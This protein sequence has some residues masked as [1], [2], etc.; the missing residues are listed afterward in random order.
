M[1]VLAAQTPRKAQ[2]LHKLKTAEH[3]ASKL[4]TLWGIV[5][6]NLDHE[7][8]GYMSYERPT[9]NNSDC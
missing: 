7:L 5:Q 2:V 4:S 9:F 6:G 1:K 8:N 3:C